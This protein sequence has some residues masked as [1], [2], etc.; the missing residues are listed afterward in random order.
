MIVYNISFKIPWEIFDEWQTWEKEVD[1]PWILA[2]D[3]FHDV[4]LYRLLEA[5]DDEPTFIIQ[6]FT[7]T[8]KN[9]KIFAEDYAADHETRIL[10][11]WGDQS[12]SFRTAMQL[13][14]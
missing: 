4:K 2:T 12:V 14:H 1:I 11:K 9:Y 6:C 3:L 8:L 7:L 10:A 13:V 5:D